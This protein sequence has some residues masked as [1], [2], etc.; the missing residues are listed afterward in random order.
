METDSIGATIFA[1]FRI[2]LEEFTFKDEIVDETNIPHLYEK[3]A[4]YARYIMHNKVRGQVHP[5]DSA[6]IRSYSY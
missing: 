3:Y 6:S 2:Y 4:G 1:T 5:I